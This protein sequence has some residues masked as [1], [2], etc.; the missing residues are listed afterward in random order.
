MAISG[1][2]EEIRSDRRSK[3]PRS[4]CQSA[5]VIRAQVLIE[6]KSSILDLIDDQIDENF[7]IFRK[8]FDHLLLFILNFPEFL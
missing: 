5:Q 4:D 1:R 8:S 6:A 3:L 2:I 7:L